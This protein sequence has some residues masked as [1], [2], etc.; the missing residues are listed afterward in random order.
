MSN[1]FNAKKPQGS[2]LGDQIRKTY[3]EE[4]VSIFYSSFLRILAVS[5]VTIVLAA[6][7][8]FARMRPVFIASAVV[9][10]VQAVLVRTRF[11]EDRRYT[12]RANLALYYLQV[13]GL[14]LFSPFQ[15]RL[16]QATNTGDPGVDTDHR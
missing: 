15:E 6:I 14:L 1:T 16:R 10:A 5:I 8:N 13:C 3:T 9:M 7:L 12:K 11:W 2:S 4:R